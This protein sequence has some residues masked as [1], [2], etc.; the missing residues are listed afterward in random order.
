[1]GTRVGTPGRMIT[2]DS[3]PAG[4]GGASMLTKPR[5]QVWKHLAASGVGVAAV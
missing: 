2:P 1:M 4:S 3:V 5:G